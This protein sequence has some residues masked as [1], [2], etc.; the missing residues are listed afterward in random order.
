MKNDHQAVN[1]LTNVMNT[2]LSGTHMYFLHYRMQG[3]WGYQGLASRAREY[4]TKASKNALQVMERILFLENRPNMVHYDEITVGRTCE[5]QLRN[6]HKIEIV[7]S[8]L[9]RESIAQCLNQNDYA[10]KELLDKI[11][12]SNKEQIEWLETQFRQMSES[13]AQKYLSDQLEF[14]FRRAEDFRHRSPARAACT[15]SLAGQPTF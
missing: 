2:L 1:G 10:S 11:F 7:L 15:A 14:P 8:G 3:F 13:G 6:Q 12:Q 9:L 4:S 5:D